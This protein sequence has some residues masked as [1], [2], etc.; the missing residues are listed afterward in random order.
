MTAVYRSRVIDSM[1][2]TV[3]NSLLRESGIN[4]P[5]KNETEEV[6]RLA[7]TII[8]ETVDTLAGPLDDLAYSTLTDV[9]DLVASDPETASIDQIREVAIA[10]RGLLELR[11]ALTEVGQR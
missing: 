3:A 11:E 8:Q 10:L 7:E 4:S 6:R 1:I 2:A 5:T 9:T